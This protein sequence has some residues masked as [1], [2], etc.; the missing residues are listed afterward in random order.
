V[1]PLDG[2]P[3]LK[4]AGLDRIGARRF[5]KP[6]PFGIGSMRSIAAMM[7][8][9]FLL[10]ATIAG[11]EPA[12]T[13]IPPLSP[14]PA[15]DP[16]SASTPAPSSESTLEQNFDARIDP[17]ALRDWLKIL[18]AEPNQVG[19]PH[20]KANAEQ[21]LAWFKE[22]GWNAHIETFDVLY[23]TPISETLKRI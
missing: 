16:T 21:I 7:G 15:S 18:A 10:G 1:Q 9:A 19:S 11:A 6:S 23:P 3:K 13:P 20:D 14:A 12:S 5:C 4:N 17:K 8:A 22:W 2:E